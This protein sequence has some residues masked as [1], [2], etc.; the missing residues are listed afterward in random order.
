MR[1]CTIVGTR[2][3]IIKLSRVMAALDKSVEHI[4]VHTG[5]NYDHSLNEIFFEELGV[6]KPDYS[7]ICKDH[8]TLRANTTIESIGMMMSKL[9]DTFHVVKPDAILILGDTNSCVAAAYVAKRKKIPVFHME[10]GNRCF[11]ERV[12]EEVNRRIVD[13]I[14]DINLPY[15]AIARENLLREGIPSDRII[16][17]NSPMNEVLAHYESEIAQSNVLAR[18]N[19][20]RG[21]YFVVSCH[22]EENVDSP[23]RLKKFI[24]LLN[25][26]AEKFHQRIIVSTHPRTQKKLDV[27]SLTELYDVLGFQS[28]LRPGIEFHQPFGLFDYVRL[29]ADAHCTLSD[30]GTI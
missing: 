8:A 21:E 16:K 18:L 17:T 14:S 7:L 12:P 26:V 10:A 6:R 25:A 30:S 1:V 24:A 29:Q 9:D 2:P 13:H 5:Q 15:S 3:E 22:R 4:L 11:D 19:L 23:A 20:N 28:A 27:A